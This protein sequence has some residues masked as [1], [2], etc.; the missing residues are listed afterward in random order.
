MCDNGDWFWEIFCIVCLFDVWE[1]FWYFMLDYFLFCEGDCDLIVKGWDKNWGFFCE[2]FL[3]N[4]KFVDGV[5]VFFV[6]K[7]CCKLNFVMF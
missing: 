3:I 2:K 6:C 4:L 5:F 1:F 7:F